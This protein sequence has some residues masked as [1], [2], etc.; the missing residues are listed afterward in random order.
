MA[1]P[2]I[3]AAQSSLGFNFNAANLSIGQDY[4]QP[5]ATGGNP[6]RA[7]NYTKGTNTLGQINEVYSKI[8]SVPVGAPVTIDLT[9]I[10]DI[11]G[12]TFAFVR[13]KG[14][15]IR[16]L[17]AAEDPTG[18][19]AV[20][21][22]VGN[23]GANAFPFNLSVAT[24]TVLVKNGA[25][26]GYDEPSAAGITVDGTHKNVMLTNNDGALAAAIQVTFW[27]ADA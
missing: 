23:A 2:T 20:S 19:A 25:G 24:T 26:W 16:V 18:N 3:S 6:K 12:T 4:T 1:L 15:L 11:L 7:T 22:T 9:S 21:V 27:G 10:A 14:W 5:A 8:I 17:T 13:V